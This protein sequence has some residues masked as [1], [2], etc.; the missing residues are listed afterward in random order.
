MNGNEVIYKGKKATISTIVG[1]DKQCLN[2]LLNVPYGSNKTTMAEIPLVW[3]PS[4]VD[5]EIVSPEQKK[6][7]QKQQFGERV[8]MK[9]ASATNAWKVYWTNPRKLGVFERFFKT[10]NGAIR[11]SKKTALKIETEKKERIKKYRW[12]NE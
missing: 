1:A 8:F 5:L 3:Y 9:K 6:F 2:V 4:T 11:F 12:L 7:Y 10:K